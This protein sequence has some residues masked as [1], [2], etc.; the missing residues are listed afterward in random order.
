MRKLPALTREDGELCLPCYSAEIALM[1]Q[2]PSQAPQSMQAPASMTM[3]SSPMEIAPTGQ[4]LSHAPQE[5][6]V[7]VILRAM[8]YTSN[9]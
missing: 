4:A 6:H 2:V 8:Y 5:T 9:K 3:W 1:G 7:S